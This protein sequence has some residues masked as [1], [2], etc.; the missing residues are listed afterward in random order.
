[1]TT[2]SRKA[3]GLW[4][5]FVLTFLISLLTWGTMAVLGIPGGSVDPKVPPPSTVGLLLLALGGFAPT[6]AGVALTARYAGSAGLR[7]LRQR[8]REIRLGW[9]AYAVIVGLPLLVVAARA[10]AHAAAGGAVSRSPVLESPVVLA[11]FAVQIALFGPLSEEF[12]WRGFAL[13]RML[14]RWTRTRASLMLGLIWAAWHLPLFFVVG[15][16]QW[17]TGNVWIEFPVFALVPIASAFVYTWLH[18]VTRSSLWAALAFH[19]TSN[20]AAS[21]W[22]T[23]AEDGLAGRMATSAVMVAAAVVVVISWRDRRDAARAI[24]PGGL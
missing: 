19:F 9:K 2:A 11:T 20:F 3:D 18:Q 1:M 14:G 17:R 5:F 23:M 6:I 7:A 8:A 13:E 21:L 24:R 12:G 16:Y 10:A 15:T 4:Q 22:A